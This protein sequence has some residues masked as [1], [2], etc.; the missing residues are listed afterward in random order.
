MILSVPPLKALAVLPPQKNPCPYKKKRHSP[1][2]L[3]SPPSSKSLVDK[4]RFQQ[5][6]PASQH[7]SKEPTKNE[8]LVNFCFELTA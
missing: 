7:V 1:F 8:F 4:R 3:A 5:K 2:L 6:C